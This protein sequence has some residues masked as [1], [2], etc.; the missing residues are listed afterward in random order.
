MKFTANSSEL[1][2]QLT[3]VSGAIGTNP[4]L[5]ILEDFLF[6]LQGDTLTITATDL[7]TFICVKIT[8]SGNTDG[9]CAIPARI[10]TET[11]KQLPNQPVIFE[12]VGSELTIVSGFGEYSVSTETASDY[13]KLPEFSAEGNVEIQSNILLNGINK[14]MFATSIDDLRPAMTGVLFHFNHSGLNFVA[15][16][17]SKLAKCTYEQFKHENEEQYIIPKKSLLLLR[18]SLNDNSDLVSIGFSKQNVLFEFGKHMIV[19]RLIDARYPHYQGVIPANN[20]KIMKVN[21]AELINSLKRIAN[22]ANKTT[23]QVKFSISDNKLTIKAEDLDTANKA[24]EKLNCE[25]SGVFEIGFNSKYLIEILNTIGGHDVKFMFSAP[26][27]AALIQN[28]HTET[29]MLLMPIILNS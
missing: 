18:N 1:K 23:N 29:T 4:V 5:P 12:N 21:R 13:P 16:D 25:F 7:E 28:E 14:T 22:F 26:N 9:A 11:L 8:V 2:E 6:V 17:A 19:T 15:T 3:I 20:D 24:S 10:L 27:R